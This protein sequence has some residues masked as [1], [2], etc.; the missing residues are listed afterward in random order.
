[1]I[2]FCFRGAASGLEG[3]APGGKGWGIEPLPR[4]SPRNAVSASPCAAAAS[5]AALT[6][7]RPWTEAE[8]NTV[9]SR[10]NALPIRPLLASTLRPSKVPVM[11]PSSACPEFSRLK[12]HG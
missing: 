5:R 7:L 2:P 12:N 10:R 1:M 4:R 6:A 11:N 3:S 8:R 9:G